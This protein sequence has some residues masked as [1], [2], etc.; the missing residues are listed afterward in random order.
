MRKKYRVRSQMKPKPTDT[1]TL[2][3]GGKETHLDTAPQPHHWTESIKTAPKKTN[4]RT[5]KQC[6]QETNLKFKSNVEN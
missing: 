2:E 1:R 5:N 4:T 6:K 3:L